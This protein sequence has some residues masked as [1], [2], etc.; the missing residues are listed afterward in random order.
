MLELY[1]W[2]T[3]NGYKVPIMMEE[4]SLP[5]SIRA[6]DIHSGE[7]NS[8][9]FAALNPNRKIPVLVDTDSNITLSESG[10]IL[11][12]L[13]EKQH[14]LLSQEAAPRASEL[15][16]LMFQMASIGPMFGQANHF[17]NLALKKVPYGIERYSK[18][19]NRLMQV[20]DRRLGETLY[21]GGEYSIADIAT[22]PW[23]RK[24]IAGG[25]ID[26]DSFPHAGRWFRE[27]ESRPAV[28]RAIQKVDVFANVS[29]PAGMSQL[30]C[31]IT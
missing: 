23:I 12:Y 4:L 21:L 14:S 5:Y 10:A 16:W 2:N 1:T 17:L 31:S 27:I 13:A 29:T 28:V 19:S 30:T 15:Q 22:W 6:V 3:P 25:F 18:E 7:Q 11:I 26:M 8:E 24:G 9:P 20:L